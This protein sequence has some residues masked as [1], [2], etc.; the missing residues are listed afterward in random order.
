[1]EKMFL[2]ARFLVWTVK[3]SISTRIEQP[4]GLIG[5]FFKAVDQHRRIVCGAAIND[6]I[7][8]HPHL[9]LFTYRIYHV[10]QQ[11]VKK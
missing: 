9:F 7:I 4:V 10:G 2:Q 11:Y 6:E 5:T 1:M 3:A 8:Y